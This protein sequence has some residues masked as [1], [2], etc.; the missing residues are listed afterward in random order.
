[1]SRILANLGQRLH[2]LEKKAHSGPEERYGSLEITASHLG[3]VTPQQSRNSSLRRNDR[4][5]SDTTSGLLR[6]NISST[7]SSGQSASP[8]DDADTEGLRTSAMEFLT[9]R[10]FSYSYDLSTIILPPRSLGDSLLQSYWDFIHPLFPILHKPGFE[11][12]YFPIWSIGG[13]SSLSQATGQIEDVLFY[14]ILNIVLAIG[15]QRNESLTSAQ[16]EKLA[17]EFYK[18]SQA[19]ISI[20]TLDVSSIEVVQLMLLRGLYLL[21]TPFADRCWNT[22]G[23]A[24]RVAQRLDLHNTSLNEAGKGQLTREMHRRVWCSCVTLERCVLSSRKES[25]YSY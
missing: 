21:Y 10:P 25:T 13:A 17:D 24:I 23:F 20:E 18:R 3:S 7:V 16:R 8:N 19:L 11:S 22:V 12:R 6:R 5:Y 1:L 4:A 14:A 2:Q 15:A 9:P